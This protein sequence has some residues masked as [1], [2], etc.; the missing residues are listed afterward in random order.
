MRPGVGVGDFV[1]RFQGT[2]VHN[3]VDLSQHLNPWMFFTPGSPC[4]T[5]PLLV[6]EWMVFLDNW[7]AIRRK[8]FHT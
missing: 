7:G 1:P 2:F 8:L 5:K 4:Q 6:V 3:R